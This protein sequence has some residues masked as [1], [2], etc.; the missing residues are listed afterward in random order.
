MNHWIRTAWF[1][2]RAVLLKNQLDCEFN[3]DLAT[4]LELLI[5]ECRRSGM[6]PD[7]ARRGALRKLGWPGLLR[8]LHREQRG[9]PVLEVLAQDVRYALRL[10][11]KNRAFTFIATFSLALGIGA[12]TAIFSV[13]DNLL[14]RSLPVHEP[15]RLV[16]VQQRVA[17]GAGGAHVLF[18]QSAFD[19]VR[20]HNQVFSEVVGFG[21]LPRPVV[22]IDGVA[23]PPLQVDFV[24]R[25]FFRDLGVTAIVGR[26]QGPSDEA[27]AV[28]SYRFWQARFN[29]SS[30]VLG[31][32][33]QVEGQ[34]FSIIGVAPRQFLGLCVA[35]S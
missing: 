26:A 32:P 27:V 10:L 35:N 16:Q 4:H 1:R 5:D 8:E 14:L 15:D 25:N 12:N 23:E 6:P 28:V 29:A 34:T 21:S 7:E 11:W 18:R 3:E 17:S 2:C 30:S 33:I 22:E 13:T 19:Y 24:S 9:I 31:K 20:T